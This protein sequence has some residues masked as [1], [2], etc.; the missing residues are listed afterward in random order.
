MTDTDSPAPNVTIAETTDDGTRHMSINRDGTPVV[1]VEITPDGTIV[2]GYWINGEQWKT[3]LTD[4][5]KED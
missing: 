1:G 4:V 3:L 5:P 2:V